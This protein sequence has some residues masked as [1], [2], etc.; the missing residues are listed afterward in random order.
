MRK[1]LWGMLF[2]LMALIFTSF[3]VTALKYTSESVVDKDTDEAT[4]FAQSVELI[5]GERL[6]IDV[7]SESDHTWKFIVTQTDSARKELVTEYYGGALYEKK[8]KKDLISPGH[9]TLE[10]ISLDKFNP[11]GIIN[12]VD[13][14]L[15]APINWHMSVTKYKPI[16]ADP[17]NFKR[18]PV[19]SLLQILNTILDYIAYYLHIRF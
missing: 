4:K 2:V 10:L 8:I 1:I 6:K 7:S 19:G 12:A 11:K 5:P 16:L 17:E 9:Y 15:T 14:E 3:T 18:D 13:I